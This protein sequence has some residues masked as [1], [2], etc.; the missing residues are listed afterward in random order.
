MGVWGSGLYSG[1]FAL[2]LRSSIRALARLP[3]EGDRLVEILAEANP[4]VA[5]NREDEEYTTFWLVIADQFAKRSIRSERARENALAIIDSG[6]DLDMMT[7]RGM[8]PQDV[9][10]RRRILEGIRAQLVAPTVVNRRGSVLKKPQEFLMDVGDAIVY[11]TSYGGCINAYF[12]SEELAKQESE[13]KWKRDGWGAAVIIDR[14]RAFDFLTW[15]RPLVITRAMTHKPTLMELRGDVPW[16]LESAATCPPL[17]WKKI[18]LERTGKFS[19]D[20]SKLHRVFPG[21]TP[22]TFAAIEDI[23]ICNRLNVGPTA[24]TVPPKSDGTISIEQILST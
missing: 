22:G 19:I 24:A 17:H 7:K 8:R 6:S 9:K 12:S 10:K 3:Y 2:D 11:P 14:G 23:S 16:K 20:E 18:G 21:M 4:D 13:G 15:Y 5:Q 1:D